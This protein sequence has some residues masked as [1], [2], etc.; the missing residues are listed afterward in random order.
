MGLAH[1]RG[2]LFP[3]NRQDLLAGS[4]TVENLLFEGPGSDSVEEIF[5][6][7]IMNIRLKQRETDLAKR[8]I[9]RG[10]VQQ[11]AAS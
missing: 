4:E 9:N 7:F 11:P 10:F 2:Q 1:Q 5:D 6:D 3:N 8:L